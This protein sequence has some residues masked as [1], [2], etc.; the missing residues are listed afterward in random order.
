MTLRQ[1][2]QMPGVYGRMLKPWNPNGLKPIK[3]EMVRVSPDRTIVDLLK[4]HRRSACP[5]ARPHADGTPMDMRL[6]NAGSRGVAA[7]TSRN[8]HRASPNPTAA[9]TAGRTS[10]RSRER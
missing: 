6:M 5:V 10:P 7:S 3:F 4:K 9:A 1:A 2:L 8:A